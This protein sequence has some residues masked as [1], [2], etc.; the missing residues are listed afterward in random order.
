MSRARTFKDPRTKSSL[1]EWGVIVLD[2]VVTERLQTPKTTK[3]FLHRTC[4]V[5]I[6]THRV[7]LLAFPSPSQPWILLD[8]NEQQSHELKVKGVA[9]YESYSQACSQDTKDTG[10]T[11][12]ITERNLALC[13]PCLSRPNLSE[14]AVYCAVPTAY[15]RKM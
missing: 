4:F 6:G 8:P 2:V 12:D 3:T 1:T 10:F 7:P 15:G 11:E 5:R 13:W 9:F 14:R